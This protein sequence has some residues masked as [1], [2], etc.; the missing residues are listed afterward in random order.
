MY[1]ESTEE[2][3]KLSKLFCLLGITAMVGSAAAIALPG[4]T[5]TIDSTDAVGVSF[6]Y[7]GTLS[8]SDTLALTESGNPCL[9]LAA[10]PAYCVNGAGVVT[11]AGTSPVGG[12]SGFTGTF[13]GTTA[14]WTFGA[15]LLEISGAGTVQIFPT[16]AANGSG[17][18]TPPLSLTLPAT[19][20]S[21]LGFG[22]FTQLNPTITFIMA[23]TLRS[24]NTGSFVLT[25]ATGTPEPGTFWLL[26][27]G[28]T[29]LLLRRR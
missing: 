11:T 23:D 27:A 19:T 25:Q 7:S 13:N 1:I 22:S 28:A 3:M 26:G 21:A 29:L 9:Q 14:N 6:I 2:F 10:S 17:S 18:A 12:S 16:N 4:G 20:L 5:L 15:I 8:G 24:D